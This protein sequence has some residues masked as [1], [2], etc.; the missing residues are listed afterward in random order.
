MM[1]AVI[2]GPYCTGAVTPAGAGPQVVTPQP[3]RR[4]MSWWSV[5]LLLPK[6][7]SAQVKRHAGG[8][9]VTRNNRSWPGSSRDQQA[10]WPCVGSLGR[11]PGGVI[12]LCCADGGDV[13]SGRAGAGGG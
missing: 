12:G 3:Q 6:M 1:M 13:G 8:Y 11:S 2:R 9:S 4:A 5:T 7:S 10:A